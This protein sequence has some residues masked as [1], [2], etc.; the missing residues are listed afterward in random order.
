MDFKGKEVLVAGGTGLIGIPLVELLIYKGAHVRI[1][2]L[3]DARRAHPDAEFWKMDLLAYENCVKACRDMDYIFNLLCM[4]G[5]L[6]VMREMPAKIFDA[7]LLLDINLL[8]AAYAASNKEGFLLTSSLAVYPQ[9]EISHED[10]VWQTFPSEHD[11]FA[12][13]AKR[14]G[15]LQVEA[16]RKEYGLE[17]F[18]IVRPTNTYGPYDDFNSATA[19][20]VPSLIRRAVRGEDPLVVWGDGSQERD[21][22]YSKDVARA[23]LFVAEQGITEPVNI[24]SGKGTT[25]KTLVDVIVSYLPKKP[26]IV[27]DTTKPSGDKKR[28]LDVSRLRSYGW[29]REIPLEEGVRRTMEWY[30]T[31]KDIPDGR[32]SIFNS[33]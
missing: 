9:S 10:A 31:E 17:R 21:F 26:T 30:T 27:W 29:E 5:S 15:E 33:K 25:I 1:V 6:R 13:W 16:Y 28:V 8:R 24:G 7:N 4:K 11:K 22:L 19:M 3:D 12:G 14:M 18:S 20:V 2:S 23:M 32:Y